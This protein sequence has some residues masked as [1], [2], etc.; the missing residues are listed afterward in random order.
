MVQTVKAREKELA[1]AKEQ[2]EAV[3][4]AVPGAI[5]W[6]GSDGL[7]IGVNHYLSESLN[8]PAEAIIGQEVGFFSG[9]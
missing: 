4:D 8:L 6:I 7:Y 1:E 9:T 3:L 5:S 2:L